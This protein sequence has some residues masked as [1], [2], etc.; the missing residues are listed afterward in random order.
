MKK[1]YGKHHRPHN[2]STIC[3]K[4]ERSPV[5]NKKKTRIMFLVFLFLTVGIGSEE[6]F[7]M[8]KLGKKF[9][10]VAYFREVISA[11]DFCL[12]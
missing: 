9:F 4:P 5:V 11:R 7:K 6:I 12:F 3:K 10:D 8:K 2:L 1:E